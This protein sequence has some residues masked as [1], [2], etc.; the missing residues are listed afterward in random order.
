MIKTAD[1]LE[2]VFSE[3]HLRESWQDIA[4]KKAAPGID[5]I[6]VD[7]FARNA[8]KKIREL[9]YRI[10]NDQYR[11]QPLVVFFKEKKNS[12]LREL[13]IPTIEDKIVAKT[14]AGFEL[15]K[16]QQI[17][18]PQNYAYRP[19][20]SA[21]KASLIV[22]QKVKDKK[23]NYVAR[24][25]IKNFFDSIN[26]DILRNMLISGGTSERL[27]N[28]IMQFA[29][30]PRFDGTQIITPH[31]GVPQGSPLGPVLSNIYLNY[32]D[33]ELN[34]E[35][36]SFLRYADD[37]II[38]GQNAEATGNNMNYA[39]QLL[40]SLKLDISI[41]KTRVY[42]IDSGFLFLGFFFNRN[43]KV[44]SSDSFEHLNEMLNSPQ[45]DDE[46]EIEYNK[47]L[48]AVLRGW[49][50]YFEPENTEHSSAYIPTEEAN[51]KEELTESAL[52]TTSTKAVFPPVQNP[53]SSSDPETDIELQERINQ[54]Y[55]NALEMKNSGRLQIAAQKFRRILS[56]DYEL[57]E[58][59][60][61][62]IYKYLIEIY[63]ECGLHGA[64]EKCSEVTGEKYICP[65]KRKRNDDIN[66]S[67]KDPEVWCDIFES[68]SPV[69]RQ[70]IDITGRCGYKPA[71]KSLNKNYLKDH[72][73]SKHT[74]SIPIFDKFSKVRFALLDLDI[75]RKYLD[76]KKKEEINALKEKLLDDARG[77]AGLAEKLGV[78]SV[79]EDSGYK[80]YHVWFFF[81]QRQNA[82][83]AKEFLQAINRTAGSPP[84][85]TH[86]ELF[87]ASDSLTND[88]LNSRIKLP[89]GKHRLSGRYSTFLNIDGEEIIN[90]I[91]L[92][93]HHT[94]F[95]RK[96]DIVKAIKELNRYHN[97][98]TKDNHTEYHS[99]S[100]EKIKKLYQCCSMLKVIC[101]KAETENRLNHYERVVLR[102]IL[103]PLGK[104]GREE[105][106]KV[107]SKCNNYSRTLTE[108]M[109]SESHSRPIGCKRIREILSYMSDKVDCT[110]NFRKMKNDYAHPLRHLKINNT[111]S[112]KKNLLNE[113]DKTIPENNLY[114]DTK[115]YNVYNDIEEKI[116]GI[117]KDEIKQTIIFSIKI[118]VWK[119]HFNI[120]FLKK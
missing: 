15:K 69:Y 79:I 107:L 91:N 86:R 101:K 21:L 48:S 85:G 90:P 94:I 113:S 96:S 66:W 62:K 59:D 72:W 14:A 41:D 30:N 92:L 71:S 83:L 70:Y 26:H 108:K 57:E 28:F 76:E 13:T 88:K 99:D 44:P 37:I 109:L 95:N 23:F 65:L 116:P 38:F 31:I 112:L 34:K 40:E 115:E 25:D 114:T 87:P 84:E 7:I 32:F 17:F 47:R 49:K 118:S 45:Y 35:G 105:I 27:T 56:G 51:E 102:G 22:E 78:K 93:S 82:K 12:L 33:K 20:R 98:N 36:V 52:N 63:S 55:Q 58:S 106:H 117:S 111:G 75:T 4:I 29:A 60:R 89:L 9:F 97:N 6:T 53:E 103:A 104:E 119:L 39:I 50:N 19:H 24:I 74:L 77:I 11:P 64:A 67:T 18:A 81:F 68:D 80:G 5:N 1:S 110:C 73:L 10:I 120:E 8:N 16:Y 2:Y 42:S 3:E 100:P 61:K 43:G 46:S 54:L